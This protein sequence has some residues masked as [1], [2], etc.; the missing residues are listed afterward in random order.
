M[1]KFL[2]LLVS[3]MLSSVAGIAQWNTN[4][5]TNTQI[6]S[7]LSNARTQVTTV[8]DGNNGMFIA[9]ID[10]RTVAGG[11]IYLQRVNHQNSQIFAA[12]GVLVSGTTTSKGNLSMIPD[13]A[14]GV[15]ISWTEN[16]D[17][18]GRKFDANGAAV[19]ASD[20]NLSFTTA[21]TQ[22]GPVMAVV[23]STQAMVAFVDSRNSAASGN[24][25]YLQ[26]IDL[27][28]GNILLA[29]D[30]PV[31]KATLNQTALQIIPDGNGGAFVAWQD[32]RVA[33]SNTSVYAMRMKNDG[34]P[35]PMWTVD[36]NVIC[37]ET[38]NQNLPIMISDKNGGV[39]IT[40]QDFR[41]TTGDIYAQRVNADGSISSGWTV[42]GEV[43][44]KNFGGQTLPQVVAVNDGAIFVWTDPRLSGSD[45]NIFAQKLSLA[46]GDTLWAPAGGGLKICDAPG[47]QPNVTSDGIR[48][49]AD[50][51]NG[52]IVMWVD[53]RNSG[54]SG[55]DI[56]A[57]RISSGGVVQWADNGILVSN[58]AQNQGNIVAGEYCAAIDGALVVWQDG[59]SGTSN[60]EMYGA[61]INSSGNLT[62]SVNNRH[63][64]EGKIK[65]FPVPAS[66]EIY[67]SLSKVK[68]G[69][70][71]VQVMDVSGRML[72]Q[73]K[74]AINGTE[75]L[76]ETNISKLQSGVYFIK[77]VHENTKAES[78]FRFVKQ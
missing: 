75:G 58:A 65:A 70:Y 61:L 44:N 22:S 42:N 19:W 73:N 55:N 56:Y 63:A 53:T 50:G 11:S 76:I 28:T 67:L 14:G 1:R 48:L 68:P 64:L 33:T 5:A 7:A 3:I 2:L 6:C 30:T 25:V 38:G 29:T 32:P 16:N 74:T 13:E 15:I 20:K 18:F 34:L 24:D 17:I 21:G 31:C 62:S 78:V 39:Y 77:L 66:K 40:W 52:V 54:T 35:D 4:T 9:W 41:A 43:V 57:Q 23:N 10:G 51:S 72:L 45:R 71:V 12:N 8:P 37:N 26:K 69:A 46:N 27:A 47:N 60:V 59:R 49:V 36:G